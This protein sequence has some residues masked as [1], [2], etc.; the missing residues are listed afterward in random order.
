MKLNFSRLIPFSLILALMMA[1][2]PVVPVYAAHTITSVTPAQIVN[3]VDTTITI[4]GTNFDAT[5]EVALGSLPLLRLTQSP[6]EITALVPAGVTAGS[7]AVTVTMG[8]DVAS[9]ASPCVTVI[10][11]VPTSTPVP[12][13]TTV[14]LLFTRPQFVVHTTKAVGGIQTGKEF[15]LNVVVE[16]AGQAT[17]Y[18]TQAVFT[19]SDLVPTKTGGVEVLG[20]V[21]YDDEVDISQTFYVTAQIYGQSI[22]VVDLTLNYYDDKGIA[23]SD[24][25]T[26]SVPVSGVVYSGAAAATATPT[27]VKSSQL[28]ITSYSTDLDTLQP[29]EHFALK[30]TVQNVGNAKAQR[31]TLIVGGGSSGSGGGT[32]QPEGVSGGSGDFAN[33]APVGASNVQSLGDLAEGEALQASQNLIVNVNTSAGAYPMRITLSYLNDKN[34]VV[35]DEQ[36]ITLLVYSLPNVDASFYRPPD[37]FFVGQPGMLPIQVENT[38]RRSSVLGNFKLSA[39]SGFIENGTSLVGALDAGG[40]FTVDSMFT[41]EQSGTQNLVVTIEYV[42]D[43]N[44]PRT[45]TKTLEIEVQGGFIEEM[46]DPSLGGGGGG[47]EIFIEEETTLHKIFRFIKGLFGLDS[48]WPVWQ[49]PGGLEQPQFEQSAPSK[50]LGGEGG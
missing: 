41:P 1:L 10:N 2:I 24:K 23:Y 7:Y 37:P 30:L 28:V 6:M 40:Y 35:N 46:P 47:G 25:F 18:N 17:A 36:V 48:S 4:A 15:K 19:S 44:Q 42:D 12:T 5:S 39:S 43:F 45:L 9:C 31:I 50:P 3:N 27:G 38:G 49:A 29:G 34:E 11:P 21:A 20:A 8:V 26:L 14:P 16:N 22:I 33:F 32:P 13:N